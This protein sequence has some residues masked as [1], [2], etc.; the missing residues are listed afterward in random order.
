[1]AIVVDKEQKR[2]DIAFAS[3]DLFLVK[4]FES[5]TISE[6]AKAASVGKGTL[7][8]YFKNKEEIVFELVEL[9]LQDYTIRLEN[10][11]SSQESVRDKVKKF[12]EFFY[13]PE[14]EELRKLYKDFTAL[15]L[16]A[17]TEELQLFQTAC[18]NNFYIWFERLF[19]EGVAKGEL[20]EE[21]LALTKGIFVTS[22]GM[23]VSSCTTTVFEMIESDINQYI[24]SIFN[25]IEVKK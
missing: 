7:Y 12:G 9:L 24:D 3:K 17:P 13:A 20:I 8:E 21:S 16:S 11:L 22:K 5:V 6:I 1:M 25:M 2:R 18:F 19:R 15:S 10:Q 23:F 14:N 4:R